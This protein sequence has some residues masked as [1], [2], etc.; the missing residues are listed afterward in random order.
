[1]RLIEL[2]GVSERSL[3]RELLT[4]IRDSKARHDKNSRTVAYMS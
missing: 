1:V 4:G 3:S 2:L